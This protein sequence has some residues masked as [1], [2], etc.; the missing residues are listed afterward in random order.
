M[1]VIMQGMVAGN[2]S[3]AEPRQRWEKDITYVWY[4][5]SSNRSGGVPASISQRHLGSDILARI[6][7]EK[8]KLGID[9][10]WKGPL[11]VYPVYKNG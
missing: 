5:D 1:Q 4:D 3:R 10:R 8:K 9:T 6:C 7:F 11:V 2:R